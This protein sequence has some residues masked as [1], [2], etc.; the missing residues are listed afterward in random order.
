MVPQRSLP[1]APLDSLLLLPCAKVICAG[2]RAHFLVIPLRMQ[3]CASC[4]SAKAPACCVNTLP[5]DPATAAQWCMHAMS[6]GRGHFWPGCVGSRCVG[7]HPSTALLG[8]TGAASLHPHAAPTLCCA[9]SCG[10]T[11]T[12]IQQAV[13][14]LAHKAAA[15]GARCGT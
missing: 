4:I 8:S 9:P 14:V 3:G 11:P 6:T 12:A 5:A 15:L 10:T 1:A 2:L 7:V 13:L